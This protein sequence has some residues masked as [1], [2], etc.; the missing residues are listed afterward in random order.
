[1]LA[2]KDEREDALAACGGLSILDRCAR[3]DPGVSG[4]PAQDHSEKSMTTSSLTRIEAYPVSEHAR[5]GTLPRHFGMHMLTVEGRIYDFMSQF[6]S[7]YDGGVWQFFE[8]SNGG[9]YMTPPEAQWNLR[10]DSN[11]F[12]GLMSSDAAGI[13]VC[14]FAFSHLS[15]EYTTD[16]FSKHFHRLREFAMNHSEAAKIFAAID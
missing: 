7:T 2:V 3:R 11:G 8:L 6:A 9:F 10:I 12:E 13:A 5:I 15:F 14:L 4:N 16:L 1:V